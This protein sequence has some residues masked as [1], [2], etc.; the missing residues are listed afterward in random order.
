MFDNTTPDI[1][2]CQSWNRVIFTSWFNPLRAPPHSYSI[3]W[4]GAICVV[5]VMFSVQQHSTSSSSIISAYSQSV[6]V[7]TVFVFYCCTST[8]VVQ[9][10]PTF[11]KPVICQCLTNYF[12]SILCNDRHLLQYTIQGVV[13][14]NKVYASFHEFCRFFFNLSLLLVVFIRR[15]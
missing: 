4:C 2:K 8:I 12:D 13:V 10:S 15:Y 7:I 3:W 11:Y 14:S 5:Q 9:C 1:S 6:I